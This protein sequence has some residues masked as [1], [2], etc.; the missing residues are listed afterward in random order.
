MASQQ[1]INDFV[2]QIMPYFN[3]TPVEDDSVQQSWPRLDRGLS[4]VQD[5]QRFQNMHGIF[6]DGGHPYNLVPHATD[7]ETNQ[8]NTLFLTT[9]TVT[10]AAGATL[11]GAFHRL[12]ADLELEFPAVSSATTYYVV[13]EYD[14]VRAADGGDPL[15]A[16]VVTSLNRSQG[17][18]YI[19]LWEVDRKP[20]QLLSDATIRRVRPRSVGVIYVWEESHKPDPSQQLWGALCVVGSTGAIYRSTTVDEAGGDSGERA[21]VPLTNVSLTQN[22][23]SYEYV[24]H[25]ARIGSTRIGQLVILEG[26]VSRTGGQAFSGSSTNGYLLHLLPSNHRPP[27]ERRFIASGAGLTNNRRVAVSVYPDGE[28]RAFPE[29]T[30]DWVSID[31][32]VFTVGR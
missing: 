16:K 5:M 17:K 14:P 21:W 19:V 6:D 28:V 31:G 7:A 1:E 29:V 30:T 4:D 24:G 8:A 15:E 26:R 22:N 25:G 12:R 32:C 13:V 2:E 23:Q 11:R 9:S 10:G 20:S 27:T 18:D 3:P